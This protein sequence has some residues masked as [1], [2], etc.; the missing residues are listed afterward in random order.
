[1]I[2]DKAGSI[3]WGRGVQLVSA[4]FTE[5]KEIQLKCIPSAF[6]EVGSV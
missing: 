4:A 2:V 3:S 1:M 5:A 6:G